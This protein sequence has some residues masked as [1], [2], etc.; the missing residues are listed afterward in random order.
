MDGKASGLIKAFQKKFK[1]AATPAVY[2]APGRVN[3]IGE[4]TD[5]NLGFVCPVA[6]DLACYVAIAPNGGDKLRIYSRN[7]G[8]QKVV[9]VAGLKD[10]QPAGDWSD[11]P[12]GVAV[13]LAKAGFKLTASDLYIDSTV[14]Q[15]GGLSSSASLE[16]ST[17]LALLGEQTMDKVE[18]AKMARA[19][20][21]QFVGMPCGIM[22]QYISVFG[23]E[24]AALKIDCRSLEFDIVKLPEEID[25]VAVNTMVKHELGDSAYRHRVA[26]TSAAAEAMGIE[27]LRDGNLRNLG[28][29]TDEVAKKRARH[30]IS[31][32]ARVEEFEAASARGDLWE[33][34]RLFVASHKSLQYDYEVSCVE[35]D[36]LVDTAVS[37]PYVY[38]ARMTGGGFG[39]CTVNIMK[40][41]AAERFQEQIFDAYKKKYKIQPVFYPV[42]PSEGARRIA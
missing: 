4:H 21:G 31:E 8:K 38:G 29:V 17:G 9:D 32:S 13:Q 28:L 19:A 26:E 40:T 25:I 30:A 23:Q 3:L 42:K 7:L 12:V 34:G 2:C 36:Y 33:M 39:G 24:H 14:P 15:G 27:S 1:T 41:G 35:L 11:Y 37:M 22:D 18:L 10:L 6:L 16:V 20:E 5:Y